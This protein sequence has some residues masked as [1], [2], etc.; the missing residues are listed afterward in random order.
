MSIATKKGADQPACAVLA[1]FA[2]LIAG[3]LLILKPAL[4]CYNQ[5]ANGAAC[6]CDWGGWFE[7]YLVGLEMR[8]THFKWYCLIQR[9][10]VT[11][12]QDGGVA[13][14]SLTEGAALWL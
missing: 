9:S 5:T 4:S 8:K 14:S 12:L 6:F 11:N 1:A 10:A 13:G 2:S 3:Y 7:F